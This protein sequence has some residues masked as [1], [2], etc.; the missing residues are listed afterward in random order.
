MLRRR[1]NVS[2][3]VVL[4]LIHYYA[5]DVYETATNDTEMLE[6]KA[7]DG[8]EYRLYMLSRYNVV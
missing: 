2:I 4:R 1:L 8:T 5:I 6:K 7:K 3:S